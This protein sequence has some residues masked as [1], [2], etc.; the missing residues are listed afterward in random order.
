MIDYLARSVSEM[1]RPYVQSQCKK[2]K[3]KLSV[4]VHGSKC[5]SGREDPGGVSGRD[6]WMCINPEIMVECGDP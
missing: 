1:E 2:S 5:R 3:K 4:Q 6:L